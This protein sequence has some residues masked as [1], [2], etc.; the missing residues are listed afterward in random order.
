MINYFVTP[1]SHYFEKF[2]ADCEALDIE[3]ID[4]KMR[5]L[6]QLILER[7]NI[8]TRYC[9]QGHNE[10]GKE[11]SV[12]LMMAGDKD[13]LS[14]V[15][16]VMMLARSFV[17]SNDPNHRPFNLE[18]SPSWMLDLQAADPYISF[19]IRSEHF[20][21]E[22]HQDELINALFDA[23]WTL[24]PSKHPVEVTSLSVLELLHRGEKQCVHIKEAPASK[25]SEMV[26]GHFTAGFERIDHEDGM[27]I[28]EKCHEVVFAE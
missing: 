3:T 11:N 6:V 24:I 12:Y 7:S 25:Q 26:F 5:D 15:S 28:C 13:A 19:T 18:V 10:V 8:F 2:K 21:S 27:A 14:L 16:E 20:Y 22:R 23:F 4:E 17:S 9:C 1:E